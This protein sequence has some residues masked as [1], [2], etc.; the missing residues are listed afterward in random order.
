MKVDCRRILYGSED[1]QQACQLRHNVLRVPLNLSLS[2]KDTVNEKNQWHFGLFNDKSLIGNLIVKPISN[3]KVKLRQMVI[4]PEMQN[5]GLGKF[6]LNH[7]ESYCWHKGYQSFELHARAYAIEF[8]QKQGYLIDSNEFYEI[9][10][11]HFKM[12]KYKT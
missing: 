7:V 2:D 1:Y 4:Q 8:Y 9:G 3:D 6:L 5:M 12:I 10:L 11:P